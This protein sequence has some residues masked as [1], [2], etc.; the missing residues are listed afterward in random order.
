[1][2]GGV[3]LKEKGHLKYK[4]QHKRKEERNYISKYISSF[5]IF[6]FVHVDFQQITQHV[7]KFWWAL[8]YMKP[9]F[10]TC[11]NKSR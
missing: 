4:E 10:S 8:K 5:V 9:G 11:V 2:G 1:M 7:I 3:K 6:F